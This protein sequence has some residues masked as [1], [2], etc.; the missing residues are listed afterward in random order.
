[1]LAWNIFSFYK[2]VVEMLKLLV[3]VSYPLVAE[4]FL[5]VHS[6]FVAFLS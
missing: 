6:I 5:D 2:M 4:A 3:A 1:M